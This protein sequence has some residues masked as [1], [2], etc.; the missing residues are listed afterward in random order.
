MIF[1]Q[2]AERRYHQKLTDIYVALHPPEPITWLIKQVSAGSV[3]SHQTN[4]PCPQVGWVCLLHW[5]TQ[6]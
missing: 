2:F 3:N 4:D 5:V 1:L 6:R